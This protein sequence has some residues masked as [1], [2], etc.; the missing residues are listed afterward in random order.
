MTRSIAATV[1]RPGARMAPATRMSA[2]RQVGRVRSARNGRSQAAR[3]SGRWGWTVMAFVSQGPPGR[4]GEVAWP[5]MSREEV[6]ARYRHLRA[7]STRHHTEAMNFLSRPAL[8]EQARH[9]GLA[10]GET[11]VAESFD[12]LTL[13]F[14]LAIHTARPDHTRAIDRYAGAAQLQP[15]SDEA[16]VLEAMRQARFSLWRV[17]R[18]HEVVGLVVQDLLRQDEVWLVDEALERSA[19]EGMV[20]AMRLCTPDTFAMT[21]GVIVPVDREADRGG[22]RRGAA[23]GARLAGPGG[24]RSPVRDSDLP[25]GGGEGADGAGRLRGG[26]TPNRLTISPWS[27]SRPKMAKVELRAVAGPRT[28]RLGAATSLPGGTLGRLNR[29]SQ[30]QPALIAARRREPRPASATEGLARSA[31]ERGSDGREVVHRAGSGRCPSGSTG[32]A[33]RWCSRSSRAAT[34]CAGRRSRP[35]ALSI[36]ELRMLRHLAP[37]S[38]VSDRRSCSGRSR[39]SRDRVADGLGAVPSECW[40]VLLASAMNA[41]NRRRCSCR[42]TGGRPGNLNFPRK[43]RIRAPPTAIAPPLHPGVATTT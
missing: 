33:A 8:L 34:G 24:Q 31:V 43:A 29:S 19:P 7:I 40:P 4:Q 28:P 27:S 12:E 17:E 32:A 20:A 38:Q 9:L 2:W 23:A 16:L 36:S 37:W 41:Q 21:C 30:R 5:S 26:T 25:H 18:R 13:A 22:P 14:D 11:L 10:A 6:L 42:A 15:G 1:R 35:Q 39:S 3:G